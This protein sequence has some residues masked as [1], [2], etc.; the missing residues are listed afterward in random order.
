MQA[1]TLLYTLPA[2]TKDLFEKS[3]QIG[4]YTE[5]HVALVEF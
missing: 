4:H 1:F 3:R 2:L 5:P